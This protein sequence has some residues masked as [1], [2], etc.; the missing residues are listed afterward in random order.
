MFKK[1]KQVEVNETEHNDFTDLIEEDKSKRE[2]SVRNLAA[3]A[4]IAV[5]VAILA[6]GLAVSSV[7][8]ST[9]KLDIVTGNM[10]DIVVAT[11]DIPTATVVAKEMVEI[12]AV[13]GQYV[14]KD[15]YRNLDDVIGKK[16]SAAIFTNQ[17]LTTST[18]MGEGNTSSL[19]TALK[20]DMSALTLA[21]DTESGLSALLHIGDRV[22]VIWSST[23]SAGTVQ[24]KEILS[25]VRVVALG[26]ALSGDVESYTSVTL[27]VSSADALVIDD[28][29]STGSLR[30]VLSSADTSDLSQVVAIDDVSQEK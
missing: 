20:Q 23:K 28:A 29:K 3:L 7:S 27:E 16:T 9:S 4:A 25:N 5:F 11:Q 15:S 21:T 14:S 1:K 2:K 8:E 12:K 13:P 22:D 19:A 26:N 6:V 30:L 10:Q 18:L 24:T 17:Q